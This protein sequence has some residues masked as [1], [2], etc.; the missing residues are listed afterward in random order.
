MRKRALAAVMAAALCVT[1]LAGC[2]SKKEATFPDPEK[3]ITLIVPQGAGGG[4]IHR[5]VSWWRP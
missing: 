3:T 4:L 5:L 1:S 2:S